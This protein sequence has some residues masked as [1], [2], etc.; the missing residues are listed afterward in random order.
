MAYSPGFT[1]GVLKKIFG[2]PGKTSIRASFGIYYTSI[3]DLNL[4]YE[5]GD[6]PF[7]LYWTTPE[8]R[9]VRRTVP[10][11]HR[12]QFAG[13]EV[14]VYLPDSRQS[15][16]QDAGLRQI[17]A[18]PVLAGL[19]H[20]QSH[21]VRRALQFLDP[22][23]AVQIDSADAGLCRDAGPQADLAVRRQSGQRGSLPAADGRWAPR[24]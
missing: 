15:G 2:G 13:S 17:S 11:A 19:R 10:H 18:D 3:E 20:S 4:F 14:P 16:E 21:A 5:V 23:R 7:G 22:A 6:A 24:T 9:S 12:R 1:D 8:Q